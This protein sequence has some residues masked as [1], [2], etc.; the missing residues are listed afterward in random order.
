MKEWHSVVL[1]GLQ[2]YPTLEPRQQRA[3]GN[4]I[5]DMGNTVDGIHK[6]VEE[7]DQVKVAASF[8]VSCLTICPFLVDP[9]AYHTVLHVVGTRVCHCS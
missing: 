5:E 4:W 8:V 1:E 6:R 7:K 2:K 3:W 9:E